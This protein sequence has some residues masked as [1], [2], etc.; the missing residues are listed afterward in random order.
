MN[1]FK[2]ADTD[3]TMSQKLQEPNDSREIN[4]NIQVQQIPLAKSN[5]S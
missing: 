1:H 3:Y 4:L 2:A 5:Q